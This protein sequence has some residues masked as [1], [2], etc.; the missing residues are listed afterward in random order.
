MSNLTIKKKLTR[1]LMTTSTMA[2]LLVC[3]MFYFLVTQHFQGVYHRDLGN[4]IDI[5]GHNCTAAL[6]FN[7]PEDAETVL[8][9]LHSR[10]SVI[11]EPT[12]TPTSFLKFNIKLP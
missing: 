4:L 1:L 9:S 8:S 11:A 10:Q 2:V 5:V 12:S 3:L 7:V 6:I